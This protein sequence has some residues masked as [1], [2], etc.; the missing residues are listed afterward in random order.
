MFLFTYAFS[1]FTS[2]IFFFLE[3]LV[4]ETFSIRYLF[5]ETILFPR[6]FRSRFL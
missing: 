2:N 4:S 5:N 6:T 1:K 3:L